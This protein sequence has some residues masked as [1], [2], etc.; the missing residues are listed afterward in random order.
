[1]KSI[2]E[3]ALS[4]FSFSLAYIF[5]KFWLNF[6]LKFVYVIFTLEQFVISCY[7]QYQDWQNT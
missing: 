2:L 1:M 6:N 7:D 5:F 4:I 3:K